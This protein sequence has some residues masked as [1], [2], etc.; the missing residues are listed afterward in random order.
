MNGWLILSLIVAL[1]SAAMLAAAGLWGWPHV[2]A[3]GV[4]G[5]LFA[6]GLVYWAGRRKRNA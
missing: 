5:G 6:G 2:I 4:Q 3:W 1:A